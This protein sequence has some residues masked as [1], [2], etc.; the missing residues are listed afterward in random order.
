MRATLAALWGSSVTDLEIN[1]DWCRQRD[2]LRFWHDL[3]R[4]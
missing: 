1:L 4:A 2:A 3:A